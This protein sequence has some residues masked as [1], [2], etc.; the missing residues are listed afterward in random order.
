MEKPTKSK[1]V[2][3]DNRHV[4]ISFTFCEVLG[5]WQQNVGGKIFDQNLS[6]LE[7]LII[8]TNVAEIRPL[9]L[10]TSFSSKYDFVASRSETYYCKEFPLPREIIHK[11]EVVHN[12][13]KYGDQKNFHLFLHQTGM[14]MHNE[15]VVQYSNLMFHE[16]YDGRAV[17]KMDSFDF[18]ES[19][20][21]PCSDL[22]FHKCK[23]K[24]IISEY[25]KTMGCSY[26]INR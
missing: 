10:N 9:T 12:A 15:M 4:G 21:I 14:F 17:L 19:P 20:S 8:Y 24:R 6:Y 23:T 1:M 7:D 26:P 18:T 11:I 25:N 13:F 3:T 5:R 2:P 22:D 16:R